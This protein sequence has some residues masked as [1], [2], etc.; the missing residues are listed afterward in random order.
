[1]TQFHTA[2]WRTA[3]AFEF[4]VWP[5]GAVLYDLGSGDT[6]ALT[7]PALEVLQSIHHTPSTLKDLVT[8]LLPT[9]TPSAEDHATIEAIVLNLNDLGLI[10]SATP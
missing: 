4:R 10:E 7:L 1:M 3:R 5:D 9:D 2:Q 8:R 6:H